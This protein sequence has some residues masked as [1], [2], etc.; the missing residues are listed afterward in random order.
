MMMMEV[1]MGKTNKWGNL[2]NDGNVWLTL[3]VDAHKM[4]TQNI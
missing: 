1:L 4:C 3:L 2:R